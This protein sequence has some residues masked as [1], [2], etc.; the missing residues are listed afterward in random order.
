MVVQD[1]VDSIASANKDIA[2]KSKTKDMKLET[3][4]ADEKQKAGTETVKA[5][6]EKTLSEMTAE[7]TEKSE[8]YKE[9][10]QLRAEELE[11]MAKAVEIL[12]SPEVSSSFDKHLTGFTQ[13]GTGR[14]ALVQ[15]RS[16]SKAAGVQR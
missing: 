11:A 10:Q 14:T 1:L 15:S 16:S 7:C 9:K 2:E 12:Q 8:S 6:N 4:A 5:A 3:A 13:S